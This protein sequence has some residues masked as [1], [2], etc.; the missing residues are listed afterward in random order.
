MER[1]EVYK[2][3][4]YSERQYKPIST[5]PQVALYTES[6]NNFNFNPQDGITAYITVGR[7]GNPFNALDADYVVISDSATGEWV[8]KSTWFITDA[9][10][11]RGKQYRLTLRRDV[12]SEYWDKLILSDVFIEKAT[13]GSGS[14]FIYNMED[15]TVNQIKQG[16]DYLI[17]DST[18]VPWIVAYFAPG[19][20]MDANVPKVNADVIIG[21]LSDDEYYNASEQAGDDRKPLRGVMTNF[22]F[23]LAGA[24]L[25]N[26]GGYLQGVPQTEWF[27][28]KQIISDV[29]YPSTSKLIY[30]DDPVFSPNSLKYQ[31][32][33][34]AT[35]QTPPITDTS[36]DYAKKIKV[37]LQRK[38]TD[39]DMRNLA[40]DYIPGMTQSQY[41]SFRTHQNEVIYVQNEG[42]YYKR[43]IS[44]ISDVK[45]TVL[46][47]GALATTF[48]EYVVNHLDGVTGT[49]NQNQDVA[50]ATYADEYLI[51]YELMQGATATLEIANTAKSTRDA[52][53]GIL[54]LPYGNLE[55]YE[56]SLL[57][58]TTDADTSMAIISELIR[59]YASSSATYIYDVQLLPYSPIRSAIGEG[60]RFDISNLE[61]NKD[62]FYIKQDT[63]NVGIALTCQYSSFS[64]AV[65][66]QIDLIN[67]KID[68]Q[69]E[70]YR[71]VSPNYDG[72]FAF[73]IAKNN[74]LT[75]FNIYCTY[76]PYQPYIQ[77]SPI[78]TNLYGGNFS[79]ARGLICGGDFSLP[80]MTDSW[81]SYQLSNKN[82]QRIFNRQ[83]ENMEVNNSITNTQRAFE[84]A[85]GTVQGGATGAAV[86]SMGG[87][88]GAIVGG[89]VGTA[90]S[91]AGGIAD[92]NLGLKSQREAI[93]YAKDQFGYNLGNIKA[94][95]NSLTKVS[96]FVASNKI[97]P[98]LEH[99]TCTADEKRALANKIAWNGMTLMIVD[100]LVNYINNTWSY[101]DIVDKGYI[102]GKLI[103]MPSDTEIDAH[104]FNTLSYELNLGVYTK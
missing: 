86:G 34:K 83:I 8:I 66:K 25:L 2:F 73:N 59:K 10:F 29:Y 94:L 65:T 1:I 13:L 53:Y 67:K 43:R 7:D 78:F 55:I 42:K 41:D 79:D 89:V 57:K 93:D 54:A 27:A 82:Y 101:N 71:V 98:F 58:V 33:F 9:V 81:A 32:V 84:I 15:M 100:R 48:N 4:N 6:G 47:P 31:V 104:T 39:A 49:L 70:L 72:Q 18:N 46:A 17:K 52:P 3:N 77:V 85:A 26:T 5:I 91:L 12:I 99:Y 23:Q 44:T 38:Y 102:K 68:N 61:E 64:F 37:L 20:A 21:D 56:N 69:T 96:S 103:R 63:T 19:N 97:F 14:P 95:P 30:A 51:T 28:Y 75:G 88:I 22:E 76:K 11:Q 50:V 45:R 92:Y 80:I 24:A 36:A 35:E 60:G 16:P 90:T 62:Y 87:P 74:G 40:L